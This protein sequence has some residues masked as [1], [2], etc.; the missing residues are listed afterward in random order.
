MNCTLILYAIEVLVA[1][2]KLVWLNP[3]HVIQNNKFLHQGT[4][5]KFLCCVRASAKQKVVVCKKKHDFKEF[6]THLQNIQENSQ[7]NECLKP[8]FPS[9]VKMFLARWIS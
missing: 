7:N 5:N 8:F 6:R 4:S 3:E 1:T 9:L 2:L